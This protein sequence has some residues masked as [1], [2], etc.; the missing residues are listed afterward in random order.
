MGKPLNDLQLVALVQEG[1]EDAF[2]ELY[3]RYK[4]P[5]YFHAGRMLDN[6]DEARDMVQ[7][8]FAAIWSKRETLV[9]PD[10]V[11]AYLYGSIL[12]P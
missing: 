10:A 5:L 11:D 8:V 12:T 1:N 9:M 2:A 7:D 3:S 6:D 4:D